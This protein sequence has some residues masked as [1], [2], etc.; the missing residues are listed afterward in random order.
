MMQHQQDT[1]GYPSRQVPQP[2]IPAP[3]GN[4][5]YGESPTIRQTPLILDRISYDYGA[6]KEGGTGVLEEVSLECRVGTW[7]AIMGPSGAGKSTLLYCAAGLLKAS[8]GRAIV[9]GQDLTRMREEELTRLRRDHIGFVF[10]D[11]NLVNAFTCLQN[12]MLSSLL[13]GR[14][15]PTSEALAALADVGLDGYAKKYPAEMSGGQRQRVAIART[16]AANPEIIM[17]DE[18]TG[19]LDT[20][21]SHAVMDL[22]GLAVQRGRTILMVTHDPNVAA[23]AHRVV[24][25]QDGHI[26]AA[27]PGGDPQS[28]ARQL[29]S[30]DEVAGL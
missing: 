25:L 28:I 12:T 20:H 6:R 13:G 23:L 29:A 18:P 2:Q 7:T 26:K 11:Y 10:Q 5:P 24:F 30:M 22:F 15:I 4:N 19:A 3:K 8:Q 21:S 14:R 17:A 16:L 27:C 1:I 9:D